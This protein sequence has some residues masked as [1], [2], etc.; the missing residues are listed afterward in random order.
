MKF[1]FLLFAFLG[2]LLRLIGL[3]LYIAT[4]VEVWGSGFWQTALTIIFVG[5]SSMYWAYQWWQS[6]GWNFSSI[7]LIFFDRLWGLPD[8]RQDTRSSFRDRRGVG[9]GKSVN[10]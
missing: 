5:L 4:I 10:Y 1:L 2:I 7:V 9:D 3:G 6:F 8:C